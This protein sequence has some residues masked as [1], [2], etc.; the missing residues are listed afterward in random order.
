MAHF[1]G[2][3]AGGTKFVCAWGSGPGD[4]HDRIV[5]PTTTPEETMQKVVSH[6][7]EVSQKTTLLGIGAAVFGPLALNPEMENYG[8]ITTTPKQYWRHFNFIGCL[9][10]ETKLPVAFD[11]DVNVTAM[12]ELAWGAGKGISDFIY[13]TVG[14]GIGA[15]AIVNGRIC[16]GALHP[17]MGHM[18]IPKHPHDQGESVCIYHD[19]C[20]EGLA[21]GPS[22]H[23][24]WGV[25]DAKHLSP[26]HKAWDLEAHYI[27]LALANM[28]FCLS[29][30][31]II[32]G[33]GVMQQRHL[34]PMI[35]D[36]LVEML[37]GYVQ[38]AYLDA[39]EDYV[40]PPQ[41]KNNAG[42][43]GAIA[44]AKTQITK[45]TVRI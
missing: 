8:C 25:S 2:I 41:L 18:F 15:G 31:R 29:P 6:I 42:V 21:S 5:I 12:G 40:V 9:H 44:L 23:A 13:V 24:R 43:L 45:K 26:D 39:I 11:T 37:G 19:K 16:H 28:T 33:G 3:E 14:T 22:L 10:N 4:L 1:Y 20:L 27:S 30:K 34:F 32:L 35:H 36:K 7:K 38:H 17:E